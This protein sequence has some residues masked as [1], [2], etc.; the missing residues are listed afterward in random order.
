MAVFSSTLFQVGQ[1]GNAW[2]NT[3]VTAGQASDS[4]DIY[5]ASVVSVFG[6]VSVLNTII[7]QL[8]QDNVNF[9]SSD[10][11]IAKKGDFGS[12]FSLGAKYVRLLSIKAATITATIAAKAG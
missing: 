8:S 12:S 11:S 9:Y 2:N 4:I 10:F 5:G 7:L 1:H 6:N 3:A